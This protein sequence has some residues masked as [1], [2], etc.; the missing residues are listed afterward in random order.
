MVVDYQRRGL[1]GPEVVRIF[2]SIT[3]Q[4]LNRL[5]CSAPAALFTKLEATFTQIS[6]S[7]RPVDQTR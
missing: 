6:V 5:V 3:G 7:F 2:V 4:R 1:A